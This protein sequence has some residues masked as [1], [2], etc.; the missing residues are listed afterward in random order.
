MTHD[1][2]LDAIVLD[3]DGTLTDT[4]ETWDHIRRRLAAEDGVPWPPEATTAMM[5]MSTP[6]WST[7]LSES[8]GLSGDPQTSARRTIDAM[9]AAYHEGL[10]LMPG[11]V[12]AIRRLAALAPLGLASSSPRVLIDAALEEMG[13]SDLFAAT[14]S[15]EEVAAG[16]PAP[17][18]YLEVCRRL[19]ADPARCV[20]VEDS[21]NG[22]RSALAAGMRVI[23]V[24]PAFHPPAAELL[25][26]VTV[27]ERL[28]DITEE[29][30]ATV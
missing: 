15:T 25:A 6:E 8:V 17:D 26:Q 20:A 1:L 19:G 21:T 29:L 13:V 10:P 12:A 14:V 24:P 9:V 16:K 4:E 22:I 3:M 30:V 27:V 28:D 23:A 11:A 2:L 7:Y 5:G 18:G